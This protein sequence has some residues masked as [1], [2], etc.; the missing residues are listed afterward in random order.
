MVNFPTQIPDY[1]S[2]SPAIWGF[3]LSSD[4]I[5]CS[6]VN[7]LHCGDSGHVTVS[8]FIG[9]LSNSV[10]D[11]PFH[12]T[13]HYSRLLYSVLDKSKSPVLRLFHGPEMWSTS[14]KSKLFAE[15]VSKNLD[16][17][18]IPLPAFSSRINLKLHNIS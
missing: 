16:D 4:Y 7:T 17:S 8:I 5:I 18:G 3:V 1:Y 11:V 9:F 10:K 6:T 2:H 15:N 12:S 14:D 13:A